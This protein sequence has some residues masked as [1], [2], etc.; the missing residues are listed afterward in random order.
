MAS[1]TYLNSAA[2]AGTLRQF[3][4]LLMLTTLAIFIGRDS[5]GFRPRDVDREK[6]HDLISLERDAI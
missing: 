5:R 6:Q 1:L 4:S 3:P 2:S